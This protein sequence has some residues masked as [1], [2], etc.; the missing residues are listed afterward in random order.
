MKAADRNARTSVATLIALAT[1]LTSCGLLEP[2]GT[3]TITIQP[4][5]S[6]PTTSVTGPN[7]SYLGTFDG[8]F[9][10]TVPAGSYSLY[11]EAEGYE[12]YRRNGRIDP[13]ENVELTITLREQLHATF[14]YFTVTRYETARIDMYGL[15][16]EQNVGNTTI[17]A[18]CIEDGYP[19]LET[20][21]EGWQVIVPTEQRRATLHLA[22]G[23]PYFTSNTVRCSF[24]GKASGRDVIIDR[25]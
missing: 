20:D 12:P 11:T 13:N 2:S 8:N 22:G 23:F 25:R 1:L 10:I 24:W 6:N 14:D 9:S 7:F 16:S 5:D 3:L 18:R 17:H 15:T 19:N 21:F 4:G